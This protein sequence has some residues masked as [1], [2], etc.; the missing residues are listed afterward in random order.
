M[1]SVRVAKTLNAEVHA[2]LRA[3]ILAGRLL[4]GQRLKLNELG[5]RFGVSLSVVRE[6][7]IRLGEQGLVQ[8]EPQLGFRV[9]PLSPDDLR[10]LTR[11]RTQI[12]TLALRQAIES[13]DLAWES[14]ALAVHHTLERTPMTIDGERRVSPAW[15]ATHAAFHRALMA[16]CG[17]PRLL[18]IADELRDS[19]EVYRQWSG[20]LGRDENRDVAGEHRALLEAVL[21]HD[22]DRAVELLTAHIGHT[23]DVLLDHAEEIEREVAAREHEPEQA[24]T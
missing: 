3:D 2:E 23:T 4:P 6:A 20:R 1:A 18:A 5:A 22:A 16:G 10:D 7:L 9:I 15:A 14:A 13:G 11:V 8:A 24:S 17:S 12:E 19:A 21:E